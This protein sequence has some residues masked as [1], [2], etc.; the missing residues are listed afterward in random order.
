MSK[1]KEIISGF[2]VSTIAATAVSCHRPK[3][4]PD[5]YISESLKK[6]SQPRPKYI[7][8]FAP[9]PNRIA[10][11]FDD[12]YDYE[13]VQ[14]VLD[15]CDGL[16]IQCTFFIV[17]TVLENNPVLWRKAMATY[18]CQICNHTYSHEYFDSLSNQQIIDEIKKWEKIANEVFGSD[19]TANMKKYYPYLR[20]PGFIGSDDKRVQKVINQLGYKII[21]CDVETM[22]EINKHNYQNEGKKNVD[23]KLSDYMVNTVKAQDIILF[24]FNDYDVN[25]QLGHTIFKLKQKNL[26]PVILSEYFQ[27]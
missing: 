25:E 9:N 6:I 8:E 7:K 10:I 13:N 3:P 2:L 19:Y 23:K 17:G 26:E 5:F 22:E 16:N 21:G 1:S 20:V 14:K 15:L 12:G 4:Q 27:K 18:G 11:T 24:H